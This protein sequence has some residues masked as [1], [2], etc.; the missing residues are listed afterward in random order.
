MGSYR[1]QRGYMF[2]EDMNGPMTGL[3]GAVGLAYKQA[4]DLAKSYLAIL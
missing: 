4:S 3:S 2:Y 1:C